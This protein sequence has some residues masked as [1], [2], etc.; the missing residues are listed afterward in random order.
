LTFHC[1]VLSMCITILSH[2]DCSQVAIEF[3]CIHTY[4][5][6][7][8]LLV[9]RTKVGIRTGWWGGRG[10][11][12]WV[13]G[14]VGSVW[15]GGKEESSVVRWTVGGR[16]FGCGRSE[17]KCVGAVPKVPWQ[18]KNQLERKSLETAENLHTENFSKKQEMHETRIT[19]RSRQKTRK[20]QKPKQNREQNHW[21]KSIARTGEEAWEHALSMCSVFFGSGGRMSR[22][23]YWSQTTR[24]I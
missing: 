17:V 5:S 23:V 13:R 11:K 15:L 1:F 14:W 4:I 19:Q 12:G 21:N 6:L 20:S 3:Q 2:F 22:Y 7:L 8:S 9:L 24:F 10:F 16:L 18:N